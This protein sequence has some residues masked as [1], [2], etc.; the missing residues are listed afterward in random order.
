M[1]IVHEKLEKMGGHLDVKSEKN[2]GTQFKL[3]LPLSLSTL[4]ECLS[5]LVANL[6]CFLLRI[7]SALSVL[8]RK[9]SK[10]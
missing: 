7:L 6:L 9:T 5:A 2:V 10:R 1:A 3:S 8:V 4:K